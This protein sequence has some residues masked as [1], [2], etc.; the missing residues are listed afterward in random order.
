M[1]FRHSLSRALC[2][3]LAVLALASCSGGGDSPSHEST[4]DPRDVLDAAVADTS[5]SK[6]DPFGIGKHDKTISETETVSYE[7]STGKRERKTTKNI[8]IR[9]DADSRV[10]EA[11][12]TLK[13]T[14]VMGAPKER[15]QERLSYYDGS[16]KAPTAYYNDEGWHRT[17]RTP[18]GEA[19][20]D[21]VP[22][23]TPSF[24]RL[25]DLTI[26]EVGQTYVITGKPHSNGGKNSTAGA[27]DSSKSMVSVTID[28]KT[29]RIGS[30]E[31][32]IIVMRDGERAFE[33]KKSLK[34]DWSP[35]DVAVPPEA[36][37]A[38]TATPS[39]T[40]TARRSAAETPAGPEPSSANT[41]ANG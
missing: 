41:A 13:T 14:G 19:P 31:S 4:A 7:A 12:G 40:P 5:R 27:I 28:R 2:A 9:I 22:V 30:V 17:S 29:R 35:V 8:T 21:V 1:T 39:T 26:T 32:R 36:K 24:K 25:K 11:K 37:S 16:A 18:D 33:A 23:D 34:Y 38:P 3:S 20:F 6:N 15:S 10:A